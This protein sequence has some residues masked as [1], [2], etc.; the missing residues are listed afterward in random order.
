MPTLLSDHRVEQMAKVT[1]WTTG[2]TPIGT[3]AKTVRV[4]TNRLKLPCRDGVEV[5][6]DLKRCPSR[7]F[8]E[9]AG[10]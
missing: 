3:R 2:T 10:S 8:H 7:R 5:R 4:P 9:G 1:K 6:F